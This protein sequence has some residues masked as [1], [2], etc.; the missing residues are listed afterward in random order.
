MMCNS[1]DAAR[2][3]INKESGLKTYQTPFPLGSSPHQL[4]AAHLW[5]DARQRALRDTCEH[6]PML[7]TPRFQPPAAA[8]AHRCFASRSAYVKPTAFVMLNC[9]APASARTPTSPVC[10]VER[11]TSARTTIGM[12]LARR[13]QPGRRMPMRRVILTIRSVGGLRR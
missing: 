7:P 6:L 9:R 12:K 5:E 13:R 1:E 11:T 3:I 8:F 10:D 4:E 2:Q